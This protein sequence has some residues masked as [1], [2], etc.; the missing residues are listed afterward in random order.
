MGNIENRFVLVT[1]NVL[2]THLDFITPKLYRENWNGPFVLG[3][4]DVYKI[5]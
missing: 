5:F 1:Q 4:V 3:K 2:T